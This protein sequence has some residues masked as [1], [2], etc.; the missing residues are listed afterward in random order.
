MEFKVG[1]FL[2]PYFPTDLRAIDNRFCTSVMYL[3]A[4]VLFTEN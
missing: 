1:S 4:V 2:L 3:F